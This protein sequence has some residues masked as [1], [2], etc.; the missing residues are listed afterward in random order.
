M[1]RTNDVLKPLRRRREV[2]AFVADASDG[3][4][5]VGVLVEAEH[6][7]GQSDSVDEQIGRD[8]QMCTEAR[9]HHISVGFGGWN[10]AQRRAR[11]LDD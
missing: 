9:E 8:R 4:Q 7:R 11:L 1:G 5:R 10:C 6:D 2:A 3:L